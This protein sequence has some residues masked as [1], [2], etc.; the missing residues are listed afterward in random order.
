MTPLGHIDWLIGEHADG[1]LDAR[2]VAASI[3]KTCT[4]VPAEAGFPPS[5]PGLLALPGGDNPE[6]VTYRRLAESNVGDLATATEFMHRLINLGNAEAMAL[7]DMLDIV[8]FVGAAEDVPVF[9]A[10]HMPMPPEPRVSK[11]NGEDVFPIPMFS[12][13]E[14]RV[15]ARLNW[16]SDDEDYKQK[17]ALIV[18]L[19]RRL[20][21]EHRAGRL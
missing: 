12:E 1:E 18:K 4:S 21:A 9:E 19:F 11:A 16:R 14:R 13:F 2:E 8:R 20:E 17:R 10:L 5:A 15:C 3:I 6:R 7:Q